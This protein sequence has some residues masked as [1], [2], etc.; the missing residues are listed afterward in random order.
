MNKTYN[1]YLE[2]VLR[3]LR[4][5]GLDIRPC[6]LVREA[7]SPVPNEISIDSKFE[8]S[9][10][11]ESDLPGIHN[12][13]P[14]MN[15]ERYRNLLRAGKLCYGLKDGANL[16]AKMWIDLE[17][18]NSLLYSRPLTAREAYLFDAFSDDSYRGQNLAPFLRLKCYAEARALGRSDI[19]SISDFTNTPARR[20]K[21]K[22]GAR[23]EALIVFWQFFNGAAHSW[24]VWRYN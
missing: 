24:I 20:F 7:E 10:L 18:I 5:I 12:L 17:E 23:D 9:Q 1:R 8:F 21:A 15:L 6:L 11:N 13:R 16:V 14:G 4:K 2:G 22:L 19:Y 3:R